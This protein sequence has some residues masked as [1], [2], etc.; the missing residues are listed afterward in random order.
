MKR[1][2]NAK[3]IERSLDF[4]RPAQNHKSTHIH[5]PT[6]RGTIAERPKY[7]TEKKTMLDSKEELENT[8]LTR[9]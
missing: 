1:I 2:R 3:K 7:V 4:T 5:I 9:N 8:S 6:K